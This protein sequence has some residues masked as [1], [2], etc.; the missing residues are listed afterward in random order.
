M[1]LLHLGDLHAYE[2]LLVAV[3]AFGPFLVLIV[4]VAVLRRRDDAEP[5]QA[6]AEPGQA[7]A[8]PG[9]A[10]DADELRTDDRA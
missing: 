8:E 4:V 3:I 10:A 6:D 9:Q 1:S 5:G 7:A 2:Q